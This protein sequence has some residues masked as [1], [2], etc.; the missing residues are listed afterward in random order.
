MI[1]LAF[2]NV[3]QVRQDATNNACFDAIHDDEASV[4]RYAAAGQSLTEHEI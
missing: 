3:G 1:A 4:A 2:N